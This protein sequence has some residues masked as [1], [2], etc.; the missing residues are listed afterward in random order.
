[1]HSAFFQA[2]ILT[3]LTGGIAMAQDNRATYSLYGTPGLLDMPTAQ[4]ADQGA[5]AFTLG[6]VEGLG[7]ATLT[8]QAT[9]R[10]SLSQRYAF[11]DLYDDPTTQTLDAK[12][13][14]SFDLRYRLTDETTYLPAIAIGFQDTLTPGRLGAEY[15]VASKSVGDRLTVTAGLG[16]GALGTRDGFTNP[17]GGAETRPVFDEDDPEGQLASDQWFRGDAALFGGVEY[18]I[19]DQ[20]GIKA[21]Y[22]SNAYPEAPFKPAIETDSPYNL[23]LTYQPMDGVQLGLAYM[24]GNTF[25]LSGSLYMN[26]NSR[27][28]MSGRESAPAPVNARAANDRS[29]DRDTA[30][31]A[32]L[33]SALATLLEREGITLTDLKITGTTARVRYINARY[34]SQAQAMGRTARMMTQVMPPAIEVF[35]LEPEARGIPLSA[36][37][38]RRSDLEQLENR[39]G[40]AATLL[41]QATFEDASGGLS[42][43]PDN[44]PAFEWG[45]GP[46]FALIPA[47]SGGS[48]SVDAGLS[49][50][51]VYT[52]R[53]NL[54]LSGAIGQS[55]IN[56]DGKDPV[57]DSTPDIQNVRTDATYYG[58]DGVPVLQNLTLAYYG[59]PGRDLY[60]RVTAGYLEQMF[61]GVST[62]VLWKPVQSQLGLGIELNYAA[63]RD[64]DM[65]FGFSEY[66]YDIVTGH[67]SAYYD[68]GNGYHTQLDVGRYLAGDWGATVSVDREFDNGIRVGAYV[69]QTDM[70]YADFGDGSYTKGVQISIPQEFLTG[71]ATRASVGTT[72]RTQVGDGGARLMVDGR[73]YNVVRDAHLAD[74]SDTWGRF[75]R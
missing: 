28:G 75:W 2:A 6:Y 72:L 64:T 45:L 69:T 8:F 20:W 37:T 21:E 13:E 39:P 3:V 53:P 17:L 38:I 47:A 5:L 27:P 14:R 62:E 44:S 16:W 7:R 10:L 60:T 52:I 30:P 26:A 73:L 11:I 58:D 57:P 40:A 63:Q 67:V 55:L 29:W 18:Q 49:L 19:N 34:R 9:D 48:V 70:S 61:G 23:G 41:Q 46:Y 66:D 4:S 54:V 68:L 12:F 71:A 36:T 15:V 65:L 33:R 50:R 43:L 1:M 59:R 35:I 22:S 31:P 56:A 74:L 25:A 51:G 42:D 24:Y 32:A